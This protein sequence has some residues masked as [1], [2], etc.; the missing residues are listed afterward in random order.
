MPEIG[1]DEGSCL[2]DLIKRNVCVRVRD[3]KGSS[4]GVRLRTGTNLEEYPPLAEGDNCP[5]S[6]NMSTGYA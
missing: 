6:G 2:R 3:G 5:F 4:S 1:W